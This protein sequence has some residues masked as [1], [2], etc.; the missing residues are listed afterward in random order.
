MATDAPVLDR[1]RGNAPHPAWDWKRVAYLVQLSRA[2]DKM[3]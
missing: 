2:L 3:E 1:H